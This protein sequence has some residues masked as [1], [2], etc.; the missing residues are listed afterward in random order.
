MLSTFNFYRYLCNIKY[1]ILDRVALLTRV[2]EDK[3][4]YVTSFGFIDQMPFNS[5]KDAF[6]YLFETN[7]DGCKI[8]V[9]KSSVDLAWITVELFAEKKFYELHS[10]TPLTYGQQGKST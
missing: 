1:Y 9:T 6:R 4:I 3:S 8:S 10:V 2:N 7:P 5:I